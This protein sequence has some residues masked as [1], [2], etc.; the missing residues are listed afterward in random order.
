MWRLLIA[1]GMLVG[2]TMHDTLP[3]AVPN[4][5]VVFQPPP[6]SIVPQDAL[7]VE[8]AEKRLVDVPVSLTPVI[9]PTSK[10]LASKKIALK[11]RPE[12][13]IKEANTQALVTPSTA[14]YREGRS[15]VQRYLY[16]PGTCTRSTQPR[17]IPAPSSFPQASI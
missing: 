5:Q 11:E 13:V 6:P 10:E 3:P 9:T 14:G 17:N 16:V 15:V 7:K 4:E 2:C 1:A 8:Q 12:K